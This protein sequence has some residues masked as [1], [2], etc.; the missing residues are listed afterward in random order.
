MSAVKHRNRKIAKPLLFGAAVAAICGIGGAAIIASP[1]AEPRPA[2]HNSTY[3][4]D[5]EKGNI[6]VI[7][8]RTHAPVFS[9][10]TFAHAEYQILR[11]QSGLSAGDDKTPFQVSQSFT[12]VSLYGP[13]LALRDQTLIEQGSGALPGGGVRY[14]TI[15]L[16]HP[17]NLNLDPKRPLAAIPQ[18]NGTIMSLA[19]LY[20]PAQI[21]AA[22]TRD[23]FVRKFVTPQAGATPQTILAALAH[24]TLTNPNICLDAPR[25]VLSSFAIV[26]AH[27]STL[28]I[29]LGLPGRGSCRGNLT[30]LGLTLPLLARMKT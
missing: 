5:V 17:H 30:N 25:D 23:P 14:W 24:A 18:P 21:T 26:A 13:Y 6:T 8:T 10:A 4:V 2:L 12:I 27:S 29:R 11:A 16:R 28:G 9:V 19:T 3:T 7:S 22:L 1:A 15:D 20:P